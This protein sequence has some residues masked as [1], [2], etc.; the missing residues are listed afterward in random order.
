MYSK[1]YSSQVKSTFYYDEPI[2]DRERSFLVLF[3]TQCLHD[4]LIRGLVKESFYMVCC[5]DADAELVEEGSIL[6]DYEGVEFVNEVADYY[7]GVDQYQRV[8][9]Q[10]HNVNQPV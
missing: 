6:P 10:D 7:A 2:P 3:R 5:Y 1:Q 9:E 4:D 8:R